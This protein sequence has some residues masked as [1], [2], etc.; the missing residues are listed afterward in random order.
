MLILSTKEAVH[1]ENEKQS[2]ES[3]ENII[4]KIKGQNKS[5]GQINDRGF[6]GLKLDVTC[7]LWPFLPEKHHRLYL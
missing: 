4:S 2:I 6:N 5:P 3:N 1:I 7:G